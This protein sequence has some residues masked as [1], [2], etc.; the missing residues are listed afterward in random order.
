MEKSRI[1]SLLDDDGHQKKRS[2]GSHFP[3]ESIE[4]DHHFSLHQKGEKAKGKKNFKF[5]FEDG[6]RNSLVF[7]LENFFIFSLNFYVF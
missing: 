7:E 1:L 5:G 2:K 6:N 3:L 4:F